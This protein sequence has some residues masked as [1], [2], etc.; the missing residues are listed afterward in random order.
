MPRRDPAPPP[1]RPRLWLLYTAAAAL[2]SLLHPAA[3]E[4]CGGNWKTGAVGSGGPCRLDGP[5]SPAE[6][7]GWLAALEQDRAATV[8]KV[9]RALT[10]SPF[11]CHTIQHNFYIGAFHICAAWRHYDC[12]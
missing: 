11:T 4:Q 12:V 8:Q 7:P 3:G 6:Q 2:S 9:H 10:L 1:G 5:A